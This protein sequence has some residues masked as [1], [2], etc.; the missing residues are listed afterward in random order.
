VWQAGSNAT[1]FNCLNM[2]D[3]QAM[4]LSDASVNAP[5][6]VTSE[7]AAARP[8]PP[9]GRVTLLLSIFLVHVAVGVWILVE[10]NNLMRS[11]EIGMGPA[12]L[13]ELAQ[14]QIEVGLSVVGL[15]VV[16]TLL[17]SF[18]FGA[19]EKYWTRHLDA[20]QTEA[21]SKTKA[22]TER[23]RVQAAEKVAAWE[24]LHK[25]KSEFEA[26]ITALTKAGR[27]M[28]E[29][30][31]RRKRVERAMSMQ[32][33]TIAASKDVL[34]IHVQARSKELQKLQRQYELILNA[35]GEGICGV[36]PEGKITFVN[37]TAARLMGLE[38][39]KMVGR[40]E[41]ELFGALPQTEP[42]TTEPKTEGRQAE[43]ILTR[44]DNSTFTAE[45]MRSQIVENDQLVGRV[46]LFKDIT[47]RKQA[48][49]ALEQKAD[50]LARS[51]AELEQFAFVAS[52]DLQEPLRKI[53]AFGDR[54][55]MKCAQ[56]LPVEGADY[57][58]RMQ[59]AAA[60]M[61]TLIA[62][63]LTFSRVISRVESFVLVDL[64]QV[65]QGVLGDLEVRI[66]KVGATVEV[67]EL[68]VIDGDPTQMRQLLQ[69]LIGNALKFQ[70]PG[71]KPHVRIAARLVSSPDDYGSG[72][73]FHELTVQD[74]GI[75]FDEK[76]LDKI[77]AVFQRLHNRQEYEGTGIGL[78][79]CRRIVD[80]HG[81]SITARSKPGAGATFV[82]QLPAR[83]Q[84]KSK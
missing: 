29:E 21:E 76:Y 69:N 41:T 3:V 7:A 40:K 81:G 2:I 75:G 58:E 1:N 35:A 11:V 49:E 33:Q 55:K 43:V 64:A 46:V 78:A 56:A 47:E 36:D 73:S 22:L 26:R 24:Q 62:D 80:R 38:V 63:L 51:N 50:E 48:A 12:N 65:V 53:R 54:L 52:H 6:E 84:K 14:R 67:G 57:L 8:T 79:V 72:E 18:L 74:N 31:D 45:F 16:L 37:P 13:R 25:V 77:F 20:A 28:E 17:A 19:V 15:G 9:A 32:S 27:E 61:Q 59:N 70:S 5:G 23:V 30:L 60:R 66:E 39:E 10:A 4:A 44:T 83:T 68:P 34:Q 82:V 71:V 42:A